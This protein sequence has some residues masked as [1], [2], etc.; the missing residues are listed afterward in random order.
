MAHFSTAYLGAVELHVVD[1]DAD[2]S[3]GGLFVHDN[4]DPSKSAR[5]AVPTLAGDVT[6][7]LPAASGTLLAAAEGVADEVDALVVG[8]GGSDYA[9]T[10]TAP[11]LAANRAVVLPS[12]AGSIPVVVSGALS[13]VDS[14]AIGDSGSAYA[15]TVTAPS[16]AANRALVLPSVAGTVA[17]VS[18]ESHEN[19]T[20]TGTVSR[21]A[22]W[23]QVNGRAKV[24]ATAGWV[25]GAA[26]DL[27]L[28]ATCP[29]EQTAA[30]LVVPIDALHVGDVVV[31][32]GV[33]CQIE[34]AGGAVTLDVALRKLT[35]ADADYTDASV[36]TLT[37]IAVTADASRNGVTTG[38]KESISSTVAA[39]EIYYFLVTATT[40]ASTDIALG[41]LTLKVNQR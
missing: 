36:S 11:S 31:G 9:V 7:T 33:N 27:G 16:L 12:V 14:V 41:G 22:Q 39:G 25:V 32:F 10:L 24:G 35:A 13:E 17:V 40:A 34:S 4:A 5:I 26:D 3:R 29:A 38:T 15:V 21:D 1:R 2:D 30:T 28:M 8:D 6:I 19:A 23:F 18:G 37:Q 20:F